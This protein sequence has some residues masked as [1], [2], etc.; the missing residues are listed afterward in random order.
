[1]LDISW[2]EMGVLIGVT[3]FFIGKQDLPKAARYAGMYVGRFVGFIQGARARADRFAANHEL[4]QLQNE[5]RSGLRELDVVKSELATSLSSRG[6]MG[7]TLGSTVSGVN[8]TNSISNTK[9]YALPQAPL[10][11][12]SVTSPAFTTQFTPAT[13]PQIAPTIPLP[14]Q[15][16]TMGAVAEEEWKRQ[17]IDFV[18]RAERG[19]DRGMNVE[20]SGSATLAFLLKESLLFSQ[21]DRMVQEQENALQNRMTAMEEQLQPH[22]D[23]AKDEK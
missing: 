11:L 20:K 12:P 2:G 6:M 13:T 7:R 21:Y 16:Q 17:G 18:S 1:M 23:Q 10:S 4:K 5:L 22:P 14:P 15:R 3:T 9:S 8:R 19:T